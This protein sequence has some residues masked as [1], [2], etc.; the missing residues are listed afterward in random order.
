MITPT[1]K[2][3]DRPQDKTCITLNKVGHSLENF[4]GSQREN[5]LVDKLGLLPKIPP[6]RALNRMYLL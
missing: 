1:Q 6:S 2:F 3:A 4:L 5:T